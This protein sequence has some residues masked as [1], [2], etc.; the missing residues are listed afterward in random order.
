MSDGRA[1]DATAD[2]EFTTDRRR[3]DPAV[4]HGFLTTSYW[5]SGRDLDTVERSMR[6]SLCFGLLKDGATV[7]FA[8]VVTDEA[9]FAWLADV[10]VLPEH[11]GRGLGKRLL[12][13][14]L[15]D[16]RLRELR[17]WMLK[18]DDAH[19]LYAQYGFEAIEEPDL[20]MTRR[21]DD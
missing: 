14:I 13:G 5:A 4:I 7:A 15:T 20:W 16:S 11:R 8:R 10:F 17:R 12:E 2:Y 1:A 21:V 3:L 18:T 6:G 9:T 19:G